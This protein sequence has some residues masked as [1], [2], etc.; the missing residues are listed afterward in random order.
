MTAASLAGWIAPA[1]TMVAAMMTAANLGARIT[2]WGFVV[3]TIGSIGWCTV[4]LATGQPNLLWTNLFLTLV[5]AVGIWRWLGREARYEAGSRA[6]ETQS[7]A[8]PHPTLTALG[9]IAGTTVEGKDGETVGTV[10]DGMMRCNDGGL[11]YLVVSVGGVAGVGE[12]LYALSADEIAI[13]ED[14]IRT[15]VPLEAIRAR[16]PLAAEAWPSRA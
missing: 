7:A 1:A 5:N 16:E 8:S 13:G 15:D 6:A 2:G 4:A 3:F 10:V 12:Q 11:A 9:S 14:A